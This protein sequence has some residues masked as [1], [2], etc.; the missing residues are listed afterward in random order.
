MTMSG[1]LSMA[2]ADLYPREAERKRLGTEDPLAGNGR[3]SKSLT[4]HPSETS[5][6]EKNFRDGAPG[7]RARYVVIQWLGVQNPNDSSRWFAR[8]SAPSP[9]TFLAAW[10]S[11][12]RR[13]SRPRQLPGHRIWLLAGNRPIERIAAAVRQELRLLPFPGARTRP[14]RQPPS[15]C[16]NLRA[17][18]REAFAELH[19]KIDDL[20]EA[21]ARA[22]G[23]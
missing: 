17:A 20:E 3:G 11:P 8:V 19:A 7:L 22:A 23:Q 13:C 5:V 14:R 18:L 4:S 6:R 2:P 15:C 12:V 16:A 10:E 21:F 1:W 9:L